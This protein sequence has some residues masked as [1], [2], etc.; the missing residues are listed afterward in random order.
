MSGFDLVAEDVQL[1]EALEGAH[2]VVTGE[3]YLD[4]QSFEGKVVGGVVA[5][6]AEH[7]VP[8]L[9]VTGDADPDVVD[10]HPELSV[11]SLVARFGDERARTE[12]AA[13]IAEVVAAEAARLRP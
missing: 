2:L 4:A 11:V 10:A 9:V 13:C 12:T 5:L 3:G 1:P 8:V 6:A 7:G